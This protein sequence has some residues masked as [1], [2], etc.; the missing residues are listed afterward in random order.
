MPTPRKSN[1]SA[2]YQNREPQYYNNG[3][4]I[5]K[6]DSFPILGNLDHLNKIVLILCM[7]GDLQETYNDGF[8]IEFDQ[9]KL[10]EI[11]EKEQFVVNKVFSSNNDNINNNNNLNASILRDEIYCQIIKQLTGHPDTEIE[12]LG[13]KVPLK[14]QFL[15][16]DD[17]AEGLEQTQKSPQ[18][19]QQ[20][21][22]PTTQSP[23]QPQITSDYINNK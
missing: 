16:P 5:R 10:K 17:I 8:G 6:H 23:S 18:E 19:Q 7:L 21:T 22:Y 4:I 2:N 14:V 15:F 11:K 9:D 1:P 3:Q 12:A 13:K 20:Q